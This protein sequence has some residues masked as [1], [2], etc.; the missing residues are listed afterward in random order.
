MLVLLLN[1]VIVFNNHDGDEI[2]Q[3]KKCKHEHKNV[4]TAVYTMYAS[5]TIHITFLHL[6][7]LWS[8]MPG[9]SLCNI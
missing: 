8:V 2:I 5:I 9:C 3:Y 1:V 4:N 7:P 6:F